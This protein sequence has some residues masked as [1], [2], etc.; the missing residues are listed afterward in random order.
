MSK[1]NLVDVISLAL[2]E[3]NTWTARRLQLQKVAQ[4][5]R[6]ELTLVVGWLDDPIMSSM[7][8]AIMIG[9]DNLEQ[10]EKY[11]LSREFESFEQVISLAKEIQDERTS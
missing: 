4:T 10:L 7:L 6:A 5:I 3:S 2:H 1:P 11:A 9:V 8:P